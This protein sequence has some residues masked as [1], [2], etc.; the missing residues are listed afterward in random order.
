[1]SELPLINNVMRE[2]ISHSIVCYACLPLMHAYVKL[3]YC[4]KASERNLVHLLR[5]IFGVRP[6]K[7]LDRTIELRT[8]FPQ[9]ACTAH[10]RPAWPVHKPGCG[11]W[12]SSPAKSQQRNCFAYHGQARGRGSHA[13]AFTSATESEWAAGESTSCA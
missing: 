2:T 9:D 6:L 8:I 5:K 4:P 11:Y 7:H 10:A 1:M 13:V 3:L 12:E